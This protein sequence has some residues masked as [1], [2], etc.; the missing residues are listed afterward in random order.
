MRPAAHGDKPPRPQ[1]IGLHFIN[2]EECKAEDDKN[3]GKLHA[4]LRYR[5][6]VQYTGKKEKRKNKSEKKERAREMKKKC[7][8]KKSSSKNRSGRSLMQ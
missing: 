4:L 3:A 2:Y 7:T 1:E 8:K 6:E 5:K